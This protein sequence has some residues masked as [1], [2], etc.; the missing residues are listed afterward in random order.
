MTTIDKHVLIEVYD[1]LLHLL[2]ADASA[3]ILSNPDYTTNI[4]KMS[5]IGD[6][7]EESHSLLKHS[8]ALF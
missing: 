2:Y 6:T 4:F 5:D 7:Y 1:D 8:D 3:F